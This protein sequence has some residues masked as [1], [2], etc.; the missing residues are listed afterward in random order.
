MRSSLLRVAR[1]M[2]ARWES[3]REDRCE[4]IQRC[5][6]VVTGSYQAAV[7]ALAQGI[8]AVGLTRS[9]YYDARL[10]GQRM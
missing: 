8:A 7:L 4:R 10:L 9:P 1:K 2:S 3:A 6:H 5:R